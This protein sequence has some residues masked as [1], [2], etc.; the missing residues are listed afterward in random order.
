M[1]VYVPV[2]RVLVRY[3]VEADV[4]PAESVTIA[5]LID[6]IGAPAIEGDIVAVRITVPV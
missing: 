2:T 4:F 6:A 1:I 5:G 3:S